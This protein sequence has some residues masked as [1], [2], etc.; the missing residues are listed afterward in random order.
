M[1]TRTS[2]DEWARR[3]ERWGRSGLTAK[4]FA[5]QTG[6]NAHTLKFWRWRLAFEAKQAAAIVPAKARGRRADVPFVEVVAA[7][8][9]GLPSGKLVDGLE[10]LLPGGLRL[11]MPMGLDEV[12]L[13]CVVAL[14]AA[15]EAR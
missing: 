10:L 3:V 9:A 15:L 11:R 5:E 6:V 8:A 1:R 4:A 7:P 12:G 13:A 2:R 14:V